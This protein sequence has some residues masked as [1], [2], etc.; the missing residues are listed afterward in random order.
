MRDFL[1]ERI[2]QTGC[3]FSFSTSISINEGGEIEGAGFVTKRY[4]E[5]NTT[6]QPSTTTTF[7]SCPY[8]KLFIMR[9]MLVENADANVFEAASQYLY[10]AL[11]ITPMTT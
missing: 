2:T 7:N 4:V 1:V 3:P 11:T 9:R 5:A 10:T 8:R 6:R